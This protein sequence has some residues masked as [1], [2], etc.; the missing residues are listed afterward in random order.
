MLNY[1]ERMEILDDVGAVY[2]MMGPACNMTCRHC[3]QTP[4]KNTLSLSPCG[5]DLSPEVIDFVEKWAALPWRFTGQQRRFYFWGGEPLLYWE[6]IKK[7]II[8]FEERGVKNVSWRIFSNGLLLNDEIADFCNV[9]D[10][11]FIMSHDAPNPLAVRN[12]VPSE[13]NCKSF[14]KIKKRTVNTV[15]SAL[16]NDMVQAFTMLAEKFPDTEISCGFINVLSKMPQ[17]IY[18]F[19]PGIVKNAVQN[20]AMYARKG[21]EDA[22]RWF[23]K[24]L[25][26]SAFWNKEEFKDYPWPPCRPGLCSLSINF[27]GDVLRCHNDSKVLGSI[28]E[29]FTVLQQRHLEEWRKLLPKGCLDCKHVNMCRCICPIALKTENNQEL[30]Y[31]DYLK[32]F[33]QAIKDEAVTK[34]GVDNG[35]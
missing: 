24:K 14:L 32:D 30:I 16:N 7:L 34:G 31:C 4:I 6:K 5:G 13:E 11:W 10:A 29:P 19:A 17:D 23:L 26:R 27:K 2:L 3:T 33:W 20:L 35:K 18:V 8:D 25:G 9:H 22:L 21:N 12:A 28:T 15:F 1:S